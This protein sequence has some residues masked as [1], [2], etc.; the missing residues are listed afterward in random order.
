MEAKSRPGVWLSYL[1]SACLH[2]RRTAM[3]MLPVCLSVGTCVHKTSGC[4]VPFP[5]L[6]W[7]RNTAIGVHG[8]T[9][10]VLTMC[11][12]RAAAGFFPLMTQLPLRSLK[13]ISDPRN[14][15]R[16]HDFFSGETT[17]SLLIISLYF[18]QYACQ[19]LIPVVTN[20]H[21]LRGLNLIE[22]SSYCSGGQKSKMSPWE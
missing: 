15:A 16:N 22:L 4:L 9:K 10:G 17:C 13:T 20:Y 7:L 5:S 12:E 21:I 2:C 1:V 18:D 14:W 3:L 11:T 8:D 19:F 6:R